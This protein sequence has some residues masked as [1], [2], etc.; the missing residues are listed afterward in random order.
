MSGASG[1]LLSTLTTG[2]VSAIFRMSV[3]R[4]RRATPEEQGGAFA[5]CGLNY[6]AC[7][8]SGASR[9]GRSRVIDAVRVGM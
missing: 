7:G 6:A 9:R 5:F 1:L 2:S 8:G 3:L 4:E